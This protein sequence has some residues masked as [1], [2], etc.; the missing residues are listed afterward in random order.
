LSRS[1]FR[2]LGVLVATLAACAPPVTVPPV[3]PTPAAGLPPIPFVDGPLAIRVVH[4]TPQSPRPQ[5]DSTFIY[6]SVGSG[7]ASLTINGH[8]VGVHAN[9]AFLGFLPV[10]ADGVWRLEASARGRTARD[11]VAYRAPPAAAA[12]AA[13]AATRETFAS[14]LAAQVTGGADTLRTGSDVAIGRPTPTGTYRWFLPRGAR[15]AADAREGDMLRVRLDGATAA[16]IP[17][18]QLTLGGAAAA[19]VAP[20]GTAR[21]VAGLEHVDLVIPAA[22]RP[23]RVEAGAGFV[24]VTVHGALPPTGAPATGS[25]PLIASTIWST[26]A[27]E[28]ARLTVATHHDVWG[29]KAFYAP[30]GALTIRLRKPPA[31]SPSAPLRGL[32]IVVDPGHPPG[33]ATGPTGLTEAEANL[34]IALQLVP[35]LRQAGADVR[36]TRTEAVTVP[37][38]TRLQMAADFDAHLLVSVHNNAFPEGVNPFRRHGTSTYYFHPFGADLARALNREIQGITQ[39]PDLGAISGNLAMVRPTWMPSALTESLFMPLPEQEAALRDPRFQRRLAEAHV[40]GIEEFVRA[41]AMR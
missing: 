9:G 40:R 24:A 15:L 29:Y 18:A 19:A 27:A 35:L 14:P 25:D 39:I 23:F 6:G 22:W 21:V 8:E 30:D 3:T 13:G 7:R 10:P 38:A 17:E 11:S 31:I 12:A 32:R 16:W 37:L 28:Q 26:P 41:R 5:V 1:R 36:A 33:G 34:A 20:L 4:P 2:V